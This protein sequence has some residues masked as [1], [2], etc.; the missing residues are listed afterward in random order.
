MC[1]QFY[2]VKYGEIF[3]VETLI[4]KASKENTISYDQKTQII[5]HIY[6][7][8]HALNVVESSWKHCLLWLLLTGGISQEKFQKQFQWH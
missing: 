8:E 3:G 4:H 6:K 7:S 2:L 1:F 5:D